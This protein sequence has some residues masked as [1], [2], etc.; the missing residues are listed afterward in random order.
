M[1][2]IL[3]ELKKI[4]G[5]RYVRWT[6]VVFLLLNAILCLHEVSIDDNDISPHIVADFYDAYIESQN[7]SYPTSQQQDIPDNI[8]TFQISLPTDELISK[9]DAQT[10]YINDYPLAIQ[11]IIDRAS[12]NLDEYK[13]T[14]IDADSYKYKYQLRI[15]DTYS[16]I[17]KNVDIKYEYA[18]GWD[19]LFNY[20]IGNIIIFLFLIVVN[21]AIVLFEYDTGAITITRLS[22]YGRYRTFLSKIAAIV[23]VTFATV[24]L[25]TIETYLIIYCESGYSSISNAIQVFGDFEYCPYIMSVGE[26]LIISLGIKTLTYILF[27]IVILT[28][29]TF[30]YN[31]ILVYLCGIILVLLNILMN[32]WNYMMPDDPLKS[33]NLIAMSNVTPLFER[34]RALNVANNV[35]GYIPFIIIFILSVLILMTVIA[36]IKYG[37]SINIV[38]WKWLSE[39]IVKI[40]MIIRKL[41]CRGAT[42]NRNYQY[43][44][45]SFEIYKMLA[46]PKNILPIVLMLLLK[47]YIMDITY[48]PTVSYSDAVYKE[49]MST[50]A[51]KMDEEKRQYIISERSIINE[52]L[53]K[54]DDINKAYL[55]GEIEFDVYRT[56]LQEYS[57]A[58]NRNEL[59]QTIEDHVTYIDAMEKKDKDAWFVYDTGWE[60]LYF[61]SFDWSLYITLIILNTKVFSMERECKSSD[62]GVAQIMRITKYG[63]E[64][65]YRT[66]Y[67]SSILITCL[68]V[69]MWNIIEFIYIHNIYDLPMLCAPVRSIESFRDLSLDM[70][71]FQ[72]TICFY[73]VKLF[74]ALLLT[75]YICSLSEIFQKVILVMT[76]TISTTLLPNLLSNFGVALM[77]HIDYTAYMRATPMLLQNSW[78]IVFSIICISLCIIMMLRARKTWI[79]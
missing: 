68:L 62:R 54:Y 51:G 37:R 67:I 21:S 53:S 40:K 32:T 8:E 35:I 64:K 12:A 10:R 6:F 78:L 73:V 52:T 9:A 2:I 76:V 55:Q 77:S 43:H 15:M 49:Y 28:I 3:Y 70:S 63:R 79:K 33:F 7:K 65:T 34:Y 25:F 47:C 66:K 4:C 11:R 26:Y 17:K 30:L 45:M 38:S 61:S 18:R 19:L 48:T 42:R 31:Y 75:I 59:F 20:Q 58:Y 29:S 16:S 24:L 39:I 50:L 36:T 74:A 46:S 72:Y 69:L 71:I 44:L 41:F 1:G 14:E 23:I 27:S 5:V 13:N 56:Y 57:Y 22:C 60:T